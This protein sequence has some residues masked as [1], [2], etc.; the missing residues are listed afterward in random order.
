MP[1]DYVAI[2][3]GGA[4]G[5]NYQLMPGDRVFIASDN[6]IAF[7]NYLGKLTAPIERLFGIVG[8]GTS[9]VRSAETLGRAY[10]STRNQ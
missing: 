5:T 7:N 10:N 1:V 2:A 6:L 4:A 3:H 8:L 9:T